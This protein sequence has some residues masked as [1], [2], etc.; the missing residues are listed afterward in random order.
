MIALASSSVISDLIWQSELAASNWLAVD[1]SAFH[2][3]NCDLSNAI[4][5]KTMPLLT[6]LGDFWAALIF[7]LMMIAINHKPIERGLKT[8]IF[9]FLIYGFV[10]A[11]QLAIKH[12]TDRPRPFFEHD[13]IVRSVYPTGFSF[14]SG[15][16]AMAFMMA[17]ILAKQYPR[18]RIA[19]YLLACLVGFSRIYLGVHYPSDVIAGAIVG[20]AIAKWMISFKNI[21][22]SIEPI[23]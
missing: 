5:D 19:F 15:H 8:G 4:L 14:P 3:I 6:H 21:K 22:E 10:F 11:S 18:Y 13:A 9:L 1:L 20:Y 16:T 12:L 23:K 7:I 17:A 2:F